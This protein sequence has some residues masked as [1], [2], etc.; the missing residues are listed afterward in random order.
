MP[1]LD[2]NSLEFLSRSADQTRRVGMRLGAALKDGDVL[3]LE[4]DLGAGKTTMVQGIASGWGSLDAVSSPT[5][6]LV[7]IYR[8]PDG[9]RLRHLDAYRLENAA[10]A[11][12]LDMDDLLR[13]GPLVVEWPGRIQEALPEDHLWVDLAY[14]TDEQRAMVFSA[15]GRHY[16][17]LLDKLQ[18]SM[19]GGG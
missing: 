14:V 17:T 9:E 16:R 8:R 6:V 12:A 19:F 10:E 1:I 7:N 15:R 3:C 5:Y 18:E 4:G 13:G 2:P 11:E